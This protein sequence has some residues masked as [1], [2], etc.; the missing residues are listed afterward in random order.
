MCLSVHKQI[1]LFCNHT[2]ETKHSLPFISR[3]CAKS[4]I[5]WGPGY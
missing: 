3:L 2:M 5:I 4:H 1:P